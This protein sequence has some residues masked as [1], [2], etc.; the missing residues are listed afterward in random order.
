VP[1]A[2]PAEI[3]KVGPAHVAC[4]SG[5]T[6]RLVLERRHWDHHALIATDVLTCAVG[7][8]P[9]RLAVTLD[10]EKMTF[11]EVQ[12]LANRFAN[13]L[14]GLGAGGGA[15]GVWSTHRSTR[16]ALLRAEPDR[17]GLRS[18]EPAYTDDELAAVL[19]YVRR[20]S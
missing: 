4:F 5:V 15:S 13:A 19:A 14:L 6:G 8:A 18:L 12:I 7:T 11:G 10:E 2:I 1:H 20:S 9:A 16:G 17:C 3:G